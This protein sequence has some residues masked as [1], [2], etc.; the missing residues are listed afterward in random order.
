MHSHAEHGNEEKTC[1]KRLT[2]KLPGLEL[3]ELI[4][5]DFIAK[6]YKLL[7]ALMKDAAK[8]FNFEFSFIPE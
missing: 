8:A 3:L 4:R 1:N 2:P 5:K 6:K 7:C